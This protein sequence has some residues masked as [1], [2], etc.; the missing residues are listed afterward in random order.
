MFTGNYIV[1]ILQNRKEGHQD[2]FIVET[3]GD[4]NHIIRDPQLTDD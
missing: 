4:D 1:F 2:R 3:T